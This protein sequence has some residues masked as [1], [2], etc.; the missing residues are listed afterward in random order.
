MEVAVVVVTAVVVEVEVGS[1]EIMVDGEDMRGVLDDSKASSDSN[2]RSFTAG[3][4]IG[5][6]HDDMGMSQGIVRI[7][8][9][10]ETNQEMFNGLSKTVRNT[11]L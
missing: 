10:E 4:K 6:V 5:L 7:K 1:V 11:C 2:I 9:M 3:G 8:I